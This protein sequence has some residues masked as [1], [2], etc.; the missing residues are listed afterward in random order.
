MQSSRRKFLK[1]SALLSSVAFMGLN[2]SLQANEDDIKWD[3][4]WDVLVVGTGFAGSIA[5]CQAVDLG[6]KTLMIDKMP[7]LGGNSAINGGGFSIVGSPQQKK[8]NIKDSDEL[9]L[10]DL[11]K[12]GRGLNNVDLVKVIAKGG[13]EVYKYTTDRG[14]KYRAALG[15]FGGH[16]V[17]RTIWP[18]INS[19][20]KIT[21]PLQKYAKKKGVDIRTR[22]ILDDFIFNKEGRVIGAK[23][24]ENYEFNFHPEI[25]EDKNKTGV[26]KYYRV[27]GG[28]IMATGGFSYDVNFRQKI[29]PTLTSD[30]DCTNHYG[31]TAHALKIFMKHD[32]KMVDI[33]QIQ[34]GPWGSPDEKGFGIAPV[35]AIPAFAYGIMVDAR[36]GKRFVNELADR[37]AR[38]QAIIKM[39]KNPDG[40]LTHPIVLCDALGATGTRK[41]NVYRGIHKKVIH[42]FDTLKELAEFYNI[43]YEGL[44]ESVNQYNADVKAGLKKDSVMGKPFFKI[45]NTVVPDISRPPFFAFRALPKVHH[46]MG[47]VGIDTKARVLNKQNKVVSGLFAAGEAVGGPHGASRLG[48]CAIPDCLVFGRIAAQSAVEL[49]NQK[50]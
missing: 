46:T 9:Y 48:S 35:F 20:G 41:A 3:E 5:A 33:D 6:A 45:R 40:S 11:L 42:K 36:N 32:M 38:S 22:V 47:G 24:R 28:I 30:I 34:L 18:E 4:D 8:N 49:L 16:S 43:P 29:D 26:V 27:R 2:S 7:V 14:V 50:G 15:Q 17:P 31:A 10:K 44:M 37:K 25:S 1:D 13:Y 19:G 23:V 39:H 21:I 12:A